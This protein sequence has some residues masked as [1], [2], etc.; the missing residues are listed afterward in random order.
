MPEAQPQDS[1]EP[2]PRCRN[3]LLVSL[4]LLGGFGVA[5]ALL[6]WWFVS[7][8]AASSQPGLVA[9]WLRAA[10]ALIATGCLTCMGAALVFERHASKALASIQ[11][12]EARFA[13][14]TRLSTDWFWETGLDGRFVRV[15]GGGSAP[16]RKG[17]AALVGILPWESQGLVPISL[18]WEEVKAVQS[19]REPYRQTLAYRLRDGHASS[20]TLEVVAEPRFDA[21]GAYCGYRGIARDITAQVNA[22]QTLERM[23]A[24]NAA[25]LDRLEL[26]VR[27]M[28]IAFTVVDAQNRRVMWNPEAERVFGYS[29][30]EALGQAPFNLHVPDDQLSLVKARYDALKNGQAMVTGINRSVTRSG[31]TLICQWRNARITD[32]QGGYAGAIAMAIDV[33][34]AHR[35]ELWRK[36]E[37]RLFESLAAGAGLSE[38]M[39]ILCEAVESVCEMGVRC[40][41]NLVID[42]KLRHCAAPH[43]ADLLTRAADGLA[44]GEESGTC[45]LVALKNRELVTENVLESD[46]WRGFTELAIAAKV[47]GCWSTPIHGDEGEVV[48]TFAAYVDR[49]RQPAAA[50]LEF[51]RM[52]AQQAALIFSRFKARETLSRNEARFRHL[53]QL[54]SDWEWERDREFRL[55][56]LRSWQEPA[57]L[58]APSLL[59]QPPWDSVNKKLINEDWA[60]FRERIERREPFEHAVVEYYRPDGRRAYFSNRGAPFHDA[61]GN[62]SGYRGVGVDI[63]KRFRADRI[64]MVE[65]ALFESM[66]KGAD[67]ALLVDI[68]AEGLS[69]VL[70][71]A[72]EVVVLQP[73]KAG[74]ESMATEAGG[75]P[76]TLALI[77]AAA[78]ADLQTAFEDVMRSGSPLF[79]ESFPDDGVSN[80]H[81][82]LRQAGAASLWV[83]PIRDGLGITLGIVCVCAPAAALPSSSDLDWLEHCARLFALV[84]ERARIADM[85]EEA[86]ERYRRLV[87]FSQDGVLIHE[88]GKIIYA[89]PAFVRMVGAADGRALQGHNVGAMFVPE[90]QIKSA[91]RLA[92][93]RA[94]GEPIPYVE[95]RLLRQDGSELEVEVG[96]NLFEAHGVRLIQ[97]QFRDIGERKQSER[98]VM[99]LNAELEL[100]VEQRTTELT[101]ANR[102][103]EAFSYTVAHDLRA[104]LRAIDGFSQMLKLDAGAS[105]PDEA[106]RDV[107]A[108]TASA[109]KMGELIDGLLSFSRLSRTGFTRQLVPTRRMIDSLLQEMP[110][111]ENVAVRIGE[112]PDSW[113]D[114]GMLRQ[115]WTNLISNAVKF[116]AKVEAPSVEIFCEVGPNVQVFQ[117]RDNGSGFDARYAG[118]LFGVFQRLHT[119]SE[120]EGTGV[121]LA[122]VKR[123]VERHGGSVGAD[124]PDE[125]GA[126]F[127][128][129]LPRGSDGMP[130]A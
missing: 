22:Q 73:G 60:R 42:G 20:G 116:S 1:A 13:H 105:L 65:R 94:T 32:A 45:G 25:A 107:D 128:F 15:E 103:L 102:E 54:A 46:A 127:W 85:A 92:H 108:I 18:G 90:D 114:A 98:E 69:G 12:R 23:A 10:G 91:A 30:Q 48:A 44:V 59:G 113:G 110:G 41:V 39:T 79:F 129:A 2:I 63:S 14:L 16:E 57:L 6:P 8:G 50:E 62:F 124:S 7:D 101:A 43:V 28:P 27:S 78:A 84:V 47:A 97:T 26:I 121:G 36:A 68:V 11:E 38:L 33:T 31:K 86:A 55:T 52:A 125:G 17:M 24:E 115:V 80:W 71:R 106:R 35:E 104:P 87:E 70:E 118:K 89:N 4:A 126:T 61:D 112:L 93:L 3:V 67:V 51:T 64:R 5:L 49:V 77:R 123:I 58:D 37:H 66:A 100:R 120:F 34:V 83:V 19:R 75:K 111:A 130:A 53:V 82:L 72:T 56:H 29:E 117:V 119:E 81:G 96:A 9:G 109:R 99:R 122:I 76:M 21:N 40:A 88:W 74:W 95:M